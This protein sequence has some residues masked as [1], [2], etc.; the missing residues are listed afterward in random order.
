MDR[1]LHLEEKMIVV[2]QSKG[3]QLASELVGGI[4]DFSVLIFWGQFEA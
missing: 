1:S 2:S 3:W 4:T